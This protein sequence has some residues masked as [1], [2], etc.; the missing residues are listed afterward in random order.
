MTL[1]ERVA[2]HTTQVVLLTA[3]AV[4]SGLVLAQKLAL[5]WLAS[6][7][8]V[9]VAAAIA[10]GF[11]H[12]SARR[13]ALPGLR[14]MDDLARK[15]RAIAEQDDLGQRLVEIGEPEVARIS[16]A[17]NELLDRVRDERERLAA[18]TL[19]TRTMAEASPN[20][21]LVVGPRG[22]IE[23][24]N[25]AFERLFSLADSPI[26]LRP[27][28]ALEVAAVQR[29]VD[30]VVETGAA[31]ELPATSGELEVL[32]LGVPLGDDGATMVVCSDVTR[33]RR[34]EQAR[35]DFVT[36]VSHELR[37]PIAAIM[38]YAETLQGDELPKGSQRLVSAIA[39]NGRRLSEL[40]EDLLALAKIEARR[41]ELPISRRK[42]KPLV[43][44]AL[45]TAHDRATS[46]GQTLEVDCPGDVTARIN[47]QALVAIVSNLALNACNY[48]PEGG[49][50]S[51]TVRQEPDA[52]VV[53][54][55]DDGIGIERTQ[56]ARIFER[57]YRVDSG[58][59]RKDGGTGLGLAIVK[60][61]CRASGADV[62]VES[63]VG[64]GSTFTV[65]FP[66]T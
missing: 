63:E 9:G 59:A 39:R 16:R 30:E 40:F 37:T 41:R 52:A 18:E 46:K 21:V 13:A 12:L 53:V 27:L 55:S 51:V 3:V 8:I 43:D 48:T 15:T 42:L 38:G 49:H 5:G 2:R 24:L 35:T 66:A 31:A 62:S 32:L 34:A 56:L 57:F 65:R 7:L 47:P 29:V 64:Q 54:V 22:R 1:A 25:P 58:R 44:E 36:N 20:G 6:A 19:R 61:L 45:S 10:M 17:V 26:G 50:I 11:A 60:H 28:E 33:F 4:L 23:Y 14:R